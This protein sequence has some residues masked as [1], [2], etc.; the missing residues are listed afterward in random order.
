MLLEAYTYETDKEALFKS[1]IS[2]DKRV[3]LSSWNHSFPLCNWTGVT[4]GRKHKRVTGLDLEGLQLGGVI[5]PSIGNLSFLISLDLSNN[6]FGGTIPQEVGNLFR[7]EDLFIGFNIILS[8]EK[9]P[10]GFITALD[11]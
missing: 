3:V 6:S 10:R 11:C 1:Q 5:S 7:L 9:F 8:E 2:Q 4:C